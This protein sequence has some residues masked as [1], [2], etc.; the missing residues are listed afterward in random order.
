MVEGSKDQNLGLQT[1]GSATEPSSQ[2]SLFAVHLFMGSRIVSSC[3][4]NCYKYHLRGLWKAVMLT[5]TA[6]RPL[7]GYT[8]MCFHFS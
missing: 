5:R 2:L 3:K 4:Q 8:L 1:S 6:Q 7:C